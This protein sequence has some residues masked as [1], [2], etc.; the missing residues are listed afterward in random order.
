MGMTV[1]DAF[2]LSKIDPWFLVQV[3]EL[4]DIEQSLRGKSLNDVDARSLFRLKRK[5]FSDKR[6]AL[7]L[8]S[9]EKAVRHYRQ[10]LDIR[11]AYKRVDTCAA[12]L[13]TSTASLYSTY[14][15]E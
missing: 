12:A 9:T 10:Q 15:A 7:L 14:G 11:P 4:I 2:N 6:L 13:A 1:E 8:G 3:K 5:G